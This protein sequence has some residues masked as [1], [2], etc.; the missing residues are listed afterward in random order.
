MKVTLNPSEQ[1]L[2]QY[3]G[4]QR[5]RN[6]ERG[7]VTDKRSF[8]HQ[9]PYKLNID[10]FGAELAACRLFNCYPDL[11]IHNEAGGYDLKHG[12]LTIDV[13]WTKTNYLIA[14]KH[15]KPGTCD[16]YLVVKGE[17]PHFDIVGWAYEADLLTEDNLTNRFR[18]KECYVLHLNDLKDPA[19]LL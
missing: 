13:K 10:G 2:A 17:L 18:G 11:A 9:N 15:K 7:G 19:L 16:V 14:P 5:Q 1:V 3:I 8:K 12:D 6:K 4:E